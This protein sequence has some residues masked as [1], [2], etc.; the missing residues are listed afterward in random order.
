MQQ[1]GG[2][3]LDG[4]TWESLLGGMCEEKLTALLFLLSGLGPMEPMEEHEDI[5]VDSIGEKAD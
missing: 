3:K 4:D 1:F 2:W 5:A